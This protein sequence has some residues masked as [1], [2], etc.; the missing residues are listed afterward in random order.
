MIDFPAC[1]ALATSQPRCKVLPALKLFNLKVIMSVTMYYTVGDFAMLW[2]GG[3][4]TLGGCSKFSVTWVS[5]QMVRFQRTFHYM[6][7]H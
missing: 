4:L 1:R 5:V 2:C 6:L 3:N 7:T